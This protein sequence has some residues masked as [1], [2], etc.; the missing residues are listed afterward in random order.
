MFDIVDGMIEAKDSRT[1]FAGLPSHGSDED[2]REQSAEEAI[3]VAAV[4]TICREQSSCADLEHKAIAFRDR[5]F[6]SVVHGCRPRTPRE[7][8]DPLRAVHQCSMVWVAEV[9]FA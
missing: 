2:T 1:I 8:S 5:T 7:A 9:D 4:V 3:R 6:I